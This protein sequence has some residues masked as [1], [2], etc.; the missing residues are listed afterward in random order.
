MRIPSPVSL[1]PQA[2]AQASLH[3]NFKTV[4]SKTKSYYTSHSYFLADPGPQHSVLW[5]DPHLLPFMRPVGWTEHWGGFDLHF[6]S[7]ISLPREHNLQNLKILSLKSKIDQE[8]KKKK[9]KHRTLPLLLR[10]TT[11]VLV[12]CCKNPEEEPNSKTQDQSIIQAG[13]NSWDPYTN[14]LPK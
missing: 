14:L 3:P 13:R 2:C 12:F 1:N 6:L 11:C 10:L 7:H 4:L 5:W 8:S 9:K